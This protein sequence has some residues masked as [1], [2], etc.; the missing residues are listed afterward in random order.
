MVLFF[1]CGCS[2]IKTFIVLNSCNINSKCETFY[3]ITHANTN[4]LICG[5]TVCLSSTSLYSLVPL[6]MTQE[7]FGN[8]S[9]REGRA[10]SRESSLLCRY[11]FY[12]QTSFS[13]FARFSEP[14]SGRWQ[15]LSPCIQA[16][17]HA[18]RL[19]WLCLQS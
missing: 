6:S 16:S 18:L 7:C 17:Q 13:V 3:Q 12:F 9:L 8:I 11:S 5:S 4:A 14:L 10:H 2:K 19:G 1:L 15:A